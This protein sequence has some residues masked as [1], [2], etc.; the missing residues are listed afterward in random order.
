MLKKTLIKSGIFFVPLVFIFSQCLKSKKQEDPRGNA[1]AGSA[2]CVSCH[3]DVYRSYLHTAHFMASQPAN[4]YTIQGS[5]AKGVN[6]LIFNPN[7]KV[8]MNKRDSGYFQTGFENGKATQSQRFDIVFG[9]IKGQTYAYWLTNELFQL[10]VSYAGNTHSWINS[11]GYAP[12]RIAFERMIGTQC[13]GCH[14]SYAK[15]EEPDLPGFY[16]GA[17]G[18]SKST[19]V[20]NIDCERCHGPAAEHVKFQTGHPAEQKAK[21]IV[22]FSSL[23]RA[24]KINMCAICHS[25]ANNHMLKPAFGYKP[26]DT[27]AN[28]MRLF[29]SNA[30]TNYKVIDVHGNQT[31]LLESSKCF[32]GSQLDCSTCHSSTHVNDRDNITLYTTRCMS[33]HSKESHNECRLGGQLGP[34][35]LKNNCISCHM[36]IFPSKV[37]IA[38]QAPT[39]IHTH[40]IAIYPEETRKILAYLKS[41]RK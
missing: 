31:A 14:T 3:K 11:P 4:S 10:P 29:S 26:Q 18:F 16:S 6:E 35:L 20:Y 9:G 37:I 17:E 36:P 34:V 12:N 40:R 13:L 39:L 30:P 24:Q 21:Y 22:A 8:V 23:T 2:A 25:G 41:D 27:L 38:G 1:Y 28:Y 5:F 32:I 15:R 33:C 7:L 19:V